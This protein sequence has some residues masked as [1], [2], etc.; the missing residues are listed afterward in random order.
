MRGEPTDAEQRLWQL[1]RAKRLVG[2]KFKRQVPIDHY[3]VDFVCLRRRLIVEA[4][5]GQH[6]AD[7]DAGRGA[8]LERQGFRILRF[9]NNDILTNEDGVTESILEALRPLTLLPQRGEGLRLT[10]SDRFSRHH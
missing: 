2:F 7:A 4:D 6:G 10:S 1:L 5:G 8:Y 9:W 3:I